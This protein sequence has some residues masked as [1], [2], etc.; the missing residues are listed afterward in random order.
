M[1]SDT[2]SS[3]SESDQNYEINDLIRAI[4]KSDVDRAENI[5]KSSELNPNHNEGIFFS[6][7][8]IHSN[9]EMCKLLMYYGA[10]LHQ[11]KPCHAIEACGSEEII[12]LYKK[13]DKMVFQA[14]KHFYKTFLSP[15]HLITS[16]GTK[17]NKKPLKYFLI[18]Q[19]DEDSVREFCD[20]DRMIEHWIE[21]NCEEEKMGKLVEEK[22]DLYGPLRYKFFQTIK[23]IVP[24][25]YHQYPI[26]E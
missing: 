22:M 20:H 14:L 25:N 10:E 11:T 17:E 2:S 19:N 8:I 3:S 16:K 1:D 7:A 26:D 21:H 18:R 6:L 23:H 24:I 15:S 13:E 4:E 9:L 5:L 12:D